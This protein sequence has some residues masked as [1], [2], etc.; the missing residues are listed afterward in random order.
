[1]EIYGKLFEQAF[2][3]LAG[4]DGKTVPDGFDSLLTGQIYAARHLLGE[5]PPDN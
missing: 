1:M 3:E 5:I 2:F 4:G